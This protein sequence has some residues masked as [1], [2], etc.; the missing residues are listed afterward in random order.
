MSQVMM[1]LHFHKSLHARLMAGAVSLLHMQW[2]SCTLLTPI[3]P[4]QVAALM[5][6]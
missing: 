3:L 4:C 2:H 5:Q 6:F 1:F